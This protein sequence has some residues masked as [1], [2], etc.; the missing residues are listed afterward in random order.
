ML[1]LVMI[2]LTVSGV[3]TQQKDWGV[4]Y[5]DSQ[6]C[7]VRGFSVSIPCNYYYPPQQ[8]Y[9]V[10]E[11]LWCSMNSNT[12]KCLNPPY[13]YDSSSNTNSDFEYAGDDKSNCTLL[14]H[15]LQFSYSGEYRFRF[16]TDNPDDR[17]T[18]VPGATLQVAG[19]C[20]G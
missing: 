17:Y 18:G 6:I 9:Q 12:D 13:V 5:P 10:V 1:H 19:K 4:E 3:F 14:I 8:I 20:Y 15:N 11:K 2:L 7:A 16:I